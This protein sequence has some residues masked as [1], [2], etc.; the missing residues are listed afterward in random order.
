MR[1]ISDCHLDPGEL[2]QCRDVDI[3]DGDTLN[4]LPYGIEPWLGKSGQN[5]VYA[6]CNLNPKAVWIAGNHD[7]KRWL[8]R[9]LAPYGIESVRRLEVNGWTIEHGHRFAADWNLL[10]HVAP[11]A[12]ELFTT[13]PLIKGWWY[14]FSQRMGW[15]AY[16]VQEPNQKYQD[17]VGLVW[18]NALRQRRNLVIG[19]THTPVRIE[20]PW[21]TLIDCGANQAIDVP[22]KLGI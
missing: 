2:P 16:G 7:P 9:L 14:K 21:F 18:A 13:L 5:T 20:T 12:V 15:M 4:L 10:R 22:A 19:H 3:F 6:C 1:L 8:D 11:D 17:F